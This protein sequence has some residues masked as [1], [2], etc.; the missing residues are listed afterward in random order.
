M[1]AGRPVKALIFLLTALAMHPLMGF[2]GLLVFIGWCLLRHVPRPYLTVLIGLSAM[3]AVAILFVPSLGNRVFGP[4]DQAWREEVRCEAPFVFGSEW[5]YSDWL[6][7]G[8]AFAVTLAAWRYLPRDPRFRDF[9]IALTVATLFGIVGSVL[10]SFLPYVLLLQ[11]QPFRS[12]WIMQLLHVPLAF[13]LAKNWWTRDG[14]P[15]RSAA[16]L[17]LGCVGLGWPSLFNLCVTATFF[18]AAL[19][20]IC[21]IA[22]A[23]RDPEWRWRCLAIGVVAIGL[24]QTA[25]SFLDLVSS[26]DLFATVGEPDNN[27]PPFPMLIAPLIGLGIG[28]ALVLV[29]GRLVGV[30]RTFRFAMLSAC[31]ILQSWGFVMAHPLVVEGWVRAHHADIR[32]INQFL[33]ARRSARPGRRPFTGRPG[34][35]NTCGSIWAS[36]PISSGNSLPATSSTARRPSR[37]VAARTW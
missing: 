25:I 22:P 14:W 34:T 32:F 4:M 23:P 13:L 35:S 7:V 19:L 27:L 37:D 5:E 26:R 16:V 12:L 17:L 15:G 33:S 2:G 28:L 1:L 20:M 29:V 6:Q 18:V 31:I 3:S 10:A 11:G 8:F 21:G 24:F 30:G 9:M 36:T